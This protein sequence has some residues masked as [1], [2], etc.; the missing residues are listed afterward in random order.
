MNSR[1]DYELIDFGNGRKLEAIHGYLLN[2]PSPAALSAHPQHSDRWPKADAIFDEVNRKWAFRTPWPSEAYIEG[3]GFRLPVQPTPFG[4]IGVFPEQRPHWRWL[5]GVVRS[6]KESTHVDNVA[7]ESMPSAPL[8]LNLFAHTGGST[9]ALAA[10]GSSVV[11]VDAAKPNVVA[12]KEASR[13]SG[14]GD[15]A[16]RYMVDDAAKFTAREVRRNRKYDVIV[17]DPPAYGHA[18][19]GKAWRL[20]RDLWPLIDD[21]LELMNVTQGA[22]L[23]TGHSEGIDQETVADYLRRHKTLLRFGKQRDISLGR[24]SL[25]DQQ[26]RGLDAGYYVRVHWL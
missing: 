13:I 14:L 17:M 20:D 15:A 21:A 9:F 18:P 25:H 11:H 16:I 1:P 5:S 12:A 19:G 2:R 8:S 4:H 6:L 26:G 10:S 24:S 7:G 23:I 3:P 22:M